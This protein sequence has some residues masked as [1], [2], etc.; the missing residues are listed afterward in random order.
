V[1]CRHGPVTQARPTVTPR[2]AVGLAAPLRATATEARRRMRPTLGGTPA[3]EATP[4]T[5]MLGMRTA[6]TMPSAARL[7][8]G[9]A[10]AQRGAGARGAG[11]TRGTMGTPERMMGTTAE[12]MG[13]GRHTTD[14]KGTA[15]MGIM[16]G[17]GKGMSIRWEGMGFMVLS[18]RGLCPSLWRLG[19]GGGMPAGHVDGGAC[20]VADECRGAG[21][22]RGPVHARPGFTSKCMRM[23]AWGEE[24]R[25]EERGGK[26]SMQ[27]SRLKPN[28]GKTWLVQCTTTMH[29][30]LSAEGLRITAKRERGG[31]EKELIE[32]VSVSERGGEGEGKRER[33]REKEFS[34]FPSCGATEC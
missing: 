20:L 32:C 24:D 21:A 12:M 15:G 23:R 9:V 30:C 13:T 17:M 28:K 27:S 26:H 25:R 31:R 14:T 29:F 4:G 1:T 18:W 3:G 10:S 33:E 8:G 6:V 22:G 7:A 5:E 34:G 16:T 19:W 2:R 11:G